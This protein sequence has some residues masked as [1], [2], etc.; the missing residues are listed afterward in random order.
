MFDIIFPRNGAVLNHNDG[1]ESADGLEITVSGIGGV[2]GNVTVN[3]VPAV[4]T[5][6][7]FAAKV[8]LRER[9]STIRAELEDSYGRSIREIQVVWDKASFKRYNFFIDD[10]IFLFTDL[11]R[12]RPADIFEHFYLKFL[13]EM[14][15]KYGTKFTLNTFFGDDHDSA[16]FTLKEMPDCYKSQ[17]QAAS[18]WLRFAFHARSEFPDRPYQNCGA[19]KLAADY[20]QLETELERIVGRECIIPP[21][22]LHWAMMR[23]EG[24]QVLREH[25]VKALSG[26]FINPRTGVDD[27][28]GASFVC[29][30]GYFMN[31]D[32]SR[33][34]EA[35]GA[36]HDFR[37]NITFFRGDVT[38]NLL[39]CEQIQKKLAAA[40]NDRR[41]WL[42]FASHEQYS[43]PRYFNYIP[44]HFQRIETAIRIAHDN[45]YKPVFFAEGFLGN[46]A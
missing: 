17:F 23:P 22:V 20:E 32:E 33:Y 7:G 25:G 1:T 38:A 40:V 46:N 16:G 28:G 12:E 2:C 43:F 30:V 29:D 36:Y 26:Q 27:N 24:F 34:L 15:E 41:E 3:G 39:T 31:L 44:D 8:T 19:D 13:R 9:F 5:G 45:G 35:A 18:D 37:Q 21:V 10:H 42:S 6:N 4:C 11:A 14:H